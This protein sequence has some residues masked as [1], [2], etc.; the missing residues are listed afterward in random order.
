MSNNIVTNRINVSITFSFKGETFYPSTSID[1]DALMN[2]NSLAVIE[3]QS[4]ML[5]SIY[6]L[7]A[8][9]INL[10]TYSYAYEIMLASSAVYSQATGIAKKHL[11]EGQFDYLSFYKE[12]QE[13]NV[14][15]VIEDIADKYH[16][17][18]ELEQQPQLKNALLDAF[19]AGKNQQKDAFK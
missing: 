10:D 14:I 6:P 2:N 17:L 1:L 13:Q 16:L 3:Q 7:M 15:N 4:N 8:A 18:T 11:R 19:Y 5:A 9:S 12:W